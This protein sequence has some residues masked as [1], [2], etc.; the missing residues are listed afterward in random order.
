[1]NQNAVEFLNRRGQKLVGVLHGQLQSKAVISLHGML[2]DKNGHKHILLAEYLAKYDLPTLRFDFAGRGDSDGSLWD[3]SYTNEVEDLD[4]AIEFLSGRGV[5]HFGLFGSSMGG[6]VALLGAARDE[7]IKA[8]ATLAAVGHPANI[9][10]TN[11]AEVDAWL[12]QGFIETE[13]GKIGRGFYDDA[14]S[15]DV[16][17]TVRVLVAPILVLHGEEDTVVPQTDALDIA[18]VARDVTL[19]IVLG[20]DH[21]FS[22]PVHLRPALKKVSDFLANVLSKF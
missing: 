18:A 1:M 4:A 11:P 19:E 8:V 2:S 12:S 15:H 14:L 3:L 9:G 22:N 21:R 13:A 7:R 20:A 6:A 17:A 16:I 10:E 5:K